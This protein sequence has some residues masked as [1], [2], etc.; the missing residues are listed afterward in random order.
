M[1]IQGAIEHGLRRTRRV[2]F[3]SRVQV[4]FCSQQIEGVTLN[5]SMEGL[6]VTVPKILPVGSSVGVSLHLGKALPPINGAD[7]VVR[8]QSTIVWAF[9]LGSYLLPKSSASRSSS[10]LWSGPAR[11]IRL[12][13]AHNRAGNTPRRTTTR[14]KAA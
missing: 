12:R 9:T 4:R 14:D 10:C 7:S 13:E 3:Q 8:L 11:I 1:A 5:V 2:P 6:L